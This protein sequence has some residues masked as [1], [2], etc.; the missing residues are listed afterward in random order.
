MKRDYYEVLGVSRDADLQQIKRA[1]RRLAR[2]LHPDANSADPDCEEK[3]KEATEAYEV[4]SDPEKRGVYDTYGHDGLRR[5]AGG[6]GGFGFDGF[7]GFG[8]LF[9]NL[10]GSFGGGF[11]RT[12]PFGRT[13]TAG[14]ARGE[15][16]A[17]DVEL[18]L[19]EAAFGVEKEI[20][21]TA[22]GVCPVCEGV[23]TTEPASVK[24]CPEC[25]GLGRVRT[26]R[27]TMLGQ[28]VQT[29]PCTRCGGQGQVIESPCRECRG[30]G[31]VYAERK[32]KV[33]IPAGID[34]GQRIRVSGRGGAGDRGAQ[35]G[36]LYV[37]VHVA[38]HE[39]FERRGDDILC[40]ADLTMVQAAV[41]T[42]VP[43]PTL[44]G[45]EEVT[46]APGTQ[47]GEV[48]VLRGRGVPHLHGHGRGDQ[49]VHVRVLIPRDLDDQ[50]RR[51]LQEFD[52]ACGADHYSDRD[53]G[54]LQKIRNWLNG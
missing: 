47:P 11:T 28:F 29:G 43:V 7:P 37:R 12:G 46:F 50:Q 33:Q 35:A 23:G 51:M 2:E 8:D 45:E 15:D 38:P 6:A 54:V 20:T 32:V 36:D 26:V 14:P 30:S 13:Q 39:V 5:G 9:E 17:L 53:E 40:R 27:R 25:S 16:L 24:T 4:L 21:F 18:T 22:Q 3:F 42:T 19:E 52:G 48:K 41:G 44:D 10:F 34:A 31:R 1:Y 49:E